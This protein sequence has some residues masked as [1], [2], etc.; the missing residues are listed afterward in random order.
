M[1]IAP[2]IL[3][4]GVVY[5]VACLASNAEHRTRA[6]LLVSVSP[7]IEAGSLSIQPLT[8]TGFETLVDIYATGFGGDTV[9][10]SGDLQF[11]F[12]AQ[13]LGQK[14]KYILK[15]WSNS[16]SLATTLM[17][18]LSVY[19]Y[20]II[21]TLH[22]RNQYLQEVT[23][24]IDLT[25]KPSTTKSGVKQME[26][27]ITDIDTSKDENKLLELSKASSLLL[28]ERENMNNIYRADTCGGCNIENGYCD[29]ITE[30]CVCEEGYQL[31]TDCY[32]SDS[33]AK[34]LEKSSQL[35]ADDLHSECSQTSN[36]T[37]IWG[38]L[39][40]TYSMLSA[41]NIITSN[42]HI[43]ITTSNLKLTPIM[44]NFT[45]YCSAQAN[46]ISTGNSEGNLEP[47]ISRDLTTKG[48]NIINN[49]GVGIG[50]ETVDI[51]RTQKEGIELS[52]ILNKFGICKIYSRE[53]LLNSNES[54]EQIEKETYIWEGGRISRME[55]KK[56]S[57]DEYEVTFPKSP[58]NNMIND[59]SR[60]ESMSQEISIV[61]WKQNP[62]KG[63]ELSKEQFSN[64]LEVS[65]YEKSVKSEDVLESPILLKFPFTRENNT[66]ENNI[67][68][69]FFNQTIN[70]YSNA[71]MQQISLEVSLLENKSSVTCLSNHL[72]MF[73]IGYW[74]TSGLQ[75][76][77]VFSEGNL[78]QIP[79][80]QDFLDHN[81]FTS[82][83]TIFYIYI[84]SILC[85]SI[86][87]SW[88][89]CSM[90]IIQKKREQGAKRV[91]DGE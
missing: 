38:N 40:L 59:S 37:N 5:K 13:I 6:E 42:T 74:K 23:E 80:P 46:Q 34:D 85:V 30:K 58:N 49:L 19:N 18:G 48:F 1:E 10:A 20:T 71:G 69:V 90:G 29:H 67:Q 50:K 88:N 84:Y 8:I 32:L 60:E 68:C 41:I 91:R 45:T 36:Q 66:N 21:I 43:N 26:Q 44:H 57:L 14:D 33:E 2:K 73:T 52:E 11:M 82:F 87:G 56:F 89:C 62:L 12:T 70:N 54:T 86:C 31:S 53:L 7:D 83:G 72:S 15:N 16:R 4:N 79:S 65:L 27:I 3:L 78:V 22:C 35:L 51:N 77:K 63:Y 39:E 28:T 61:N 9:V 76:G 25:S 17:N 64:T 24:S 75:V 47:L 81:P 55:S